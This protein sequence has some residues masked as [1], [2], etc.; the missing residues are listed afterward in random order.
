MDFYYYLCSVP[1]KITVMKVFEG[2]TTSRAI[3]EILERNNL[4]EQEIFFTDCIY[5]DANGILSE[6]LSVKLEWGNMI[7]KIDVNGEIN[8][9]SYPNLPILTLCYLRLQQYERNCKI[10]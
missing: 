3:R 1:I 7:Y 4:R 9:Y 2:L 8:N 10:N 5:T 6:L